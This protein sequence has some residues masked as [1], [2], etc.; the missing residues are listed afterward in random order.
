M[1]Q[2]KLSR[3]NE[4]MDEVVR[5]GEIAGINALIVQNG[6]EQYYYETGYADMAA[7]K[8][9]K[10]DTIFR[11]YSMTK[12]I[13]SAA[14][15]KLFEDGMIDLVDPVSKYLPGFKNP[16]IYVDGKKQDT[17]CEVTIHHLLAMSSGLTYGGDDE[18]GKTTWDLLVQTADS[19]YGDNAI[20]TVEF[21]NRLGQCPLA[22]TPGERF[23]YGLSADVLGAV[24]EVVSGMRFGDY[25]KK[26]FF[27]PLGM[28]DTDFYVPAE[29]QDRLTKVYE[30]T[31]EGLKEYYVNHLAI[32]NK[33][34][35]RPAFESGGA[36]LVSTLDDYMKFGQMLLNKGIYQGKRILSE[37]T[38]E[39]MTNTRT[40][41][42]V[43]AG[44]E[45]WDGLQGFEYRNLLRIANDR[46]AFTFNASVGEYG[47]DGWLGA[48]F[49][50]LPAENTT[51]L[52]MVQKT[53]TGTAPFTRRIRNVIATAF[54]E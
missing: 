13:T 46:T 16:H 1:K 44:F 33:M 23:C 26:N 8:P 47:W 25:L 35:I 12:P 49:A 22:F 45:L 54:E 21:A 2:E 38:V 43:R 18:N 31:E 17:V 37:K 5:D 11:L 32:L 53:D 27:E 52:L 29:K 14:V 24:V 40:V 42:D 39:Y 41:G 48:Y 28:V 15:M 20:G 9:I 51:I 3:V 36:G 34:D 7:K 10:R 19:Q 50:N 6:E 30:K 4:I